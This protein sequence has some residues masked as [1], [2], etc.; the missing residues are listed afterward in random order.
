[1]RTYRQLTEVQRYQIEILLK[2][3][4]SYTE[5]ADI[6]GVHKSTISRELARNS[7]ARGLY[8]ARDAHEHCLI[9]RLYKPKATK[10]T[11]PTRSLGRSYLG[12]DLSPEQVCAVLYSGHNI[13]LCHETIYRFVIQ[14]KVEGGI[15]H[16]HLRQRFK[17]NKKRYGS[18][19]RRG[20]IEGRISIENRPA[21]VDRKGRVGDWEVDT[22]IGKNHKGA[23]ITIVERKTNFLLVKHVTKRTATRVAETI[24]ALMMPYKDRVKTITCDNGK[25]FTEHRKI[26]Q[27]LQCRVY[28]AHPFSSWERGLNENTNGL[29]RQYFPKGCELGKVSSTRVKMAMDRINNRPRKLLNWY[30][31]NELF[32][33]LPFQYMKA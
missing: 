19:N 5:I 3:G 1:M 32:L 4:Y 23:L 31:P 6:L 11:G 17:R 9:R 28:F 13:S 29:I 24:V 26:A 20:Y 18:Q 14:D 27:L 15:L 7:N 2:E 10:M 12:Q 33:G 8:R 22:M 16:Q 21:V 30:T 25:E